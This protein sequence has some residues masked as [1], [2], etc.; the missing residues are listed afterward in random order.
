MPYSVRVA[1]LAALLFGL[2]A[3]A[4][5]PPPVPSPPP[6]QPAAP[7]PVRSIV[8]QHPW[9]KD[10][11]H[12]AYRRGGEYDAQ[13]LAAV[14]DLFRDRRTGE[15]HPIDP[16]LLDLL[17]DL[18]AALGLPETHPVHVVSGYRSPTAAKSGSLHTRGE[19]ADIRIPGVP[20]YK[21]AAA[22][23]EIARGGW[24]HYPGTDHVHVDV[25]PVRTWA[26]R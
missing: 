1:A 17:W 14:S 23:A 2:A 7:A 10:R 20:G 3:C 6:V 8:L 26:A 12:V 4:V 25:G 16:R 24:A 11:V 5:R 19:A 13:A 22:T 15:V 21:V 18:R 9:Q